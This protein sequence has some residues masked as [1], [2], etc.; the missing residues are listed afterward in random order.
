M[1]DTV[2]WYTTRGAGAVSEILLTCVVV[3]GILSVLRVQGGMWPRFVTTGLHRNLALMT[4]VFLTLHIITAM[5]DPF[6]NLGIAALIPFASYYRTFW[7][8]LGAIAFEL[9]FAIVVTSLVRGW[10]GQR[11]WRVVHWLSYAAWP[12]GVV[13]GLGT[14]TDTWSAWMLA[15]TAAC[16]AAVGVSLVWR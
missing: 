11:A 2:L 1:S 6:T 16:V 14:G 5:V 15:I 12:I 8:G 4:L 10:L 9:L 3:L 7:L 13:H